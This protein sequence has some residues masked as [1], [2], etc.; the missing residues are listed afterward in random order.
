MAAGNILVETNGSANSRISCLRA[1]TNLGKGAGLN[2]KPRVQR[3]V[4][5]TLVLYW[6]HREIVGLPRG[7]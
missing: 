4:E 3:A 6:R 2:G 5:G 7:R 1:P